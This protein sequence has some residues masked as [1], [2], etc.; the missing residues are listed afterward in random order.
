[1]AACENLLVGAR[2]AVLALE[3]VGARR[4]LFLVGQHLVVGAA[5]LAVLGLVDAEEH[6][7]VVGLDGR[8]HVGRLVRGRLREAGLG[9]RGGRRGRGGACATTVRCLKPLACGL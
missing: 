1:M 9:A 6:A 4:H 3:H 5:E 8:G 2:E 7:V